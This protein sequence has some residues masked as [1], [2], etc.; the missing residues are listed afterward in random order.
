MNECDCCELSAEEVSLK[1]YRVE[2]ENGTEIDILVCDFCYETYYKT[3][4]IKG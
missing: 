3:S 2:N 1:K 4:G